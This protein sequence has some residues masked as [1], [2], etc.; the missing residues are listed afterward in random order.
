MIRGL[1]N[2]NETW[3]N[4]DEADELVER[5]HAVLV[6]RGLCE[7]R[8]HRRGRNGVSRKLAL[9]VGTVDPQERAVLS[10]IFAKVDR[11][12]VTPDVWAEIVSFKERHEIP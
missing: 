8:P 1:T 5:D 9:R 12:S 4:D 3:G 6:S 11:E 10:R 2:G 7:R